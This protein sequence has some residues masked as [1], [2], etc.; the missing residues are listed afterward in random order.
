[1]HPL[2]ITKQSTSKNS[3]PTDLSIRISRRLQGAEALDGPSLED[4]ERSA[5][6]L[7]RLRM[8]P[9]KENENNS[10]PQGQTKK[11]N[12]TS[13]SNSGLKPSQCTS[14]GN[15]NC[16]SSKSSSIKKPV[17]KDI[18]GSKSYRSRRRRRFKR[19][20]IDSD[21]DD[22]VEIQDNG[23]DDDE[24]EEDD[25]NDVSVNDEDT[26]NQEDMDAEEEVAIDGTIHVSP[27]RETRH[28]P[29]RSS[30]DRSA[31]SKSPR[32]DAAN[33]CLSVDVHMKSPKDNAKSPSQRSPRAE[34]QKSPQQ[35]SRS[36]NES[37][38]RSRS[39]RL[40][41]GHMISRHSSGSR[42]PRAQENQTASA[43]ELEHKSPRNIASSEKTPKQNTQSRTVNSSEEP[44]SQN[45]SQ[46]EVPSS[47]DKD[48]L[49]SVLPLNNFVDSGIGSSDSNGDSNDSVGKLTSSSENSEQISLTKPQVFTFLLFRSWECYEN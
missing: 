4:V 28:S 30:T 9:T 42:S 18:W 24:E 31:G 23:D 41:S 29:R 1:M 26:E 17:K 40:E 7:K 21:G 5:R 12:P 22:F 39:P 2:A 49:K 44:T 11:Q 36:Q 43:P 47:I 19:K 46:N 37:P 20:R 45:S 6:A 8:S 3:T 35:S 34:S 27:K 10:T 16:S 13:K 33:E 15:K 38:N 25:A 48:N 14:S 32:R